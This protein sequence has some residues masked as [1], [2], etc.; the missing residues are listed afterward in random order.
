MMD[1]IAVLI[2]V[3]LWIFGGAAAFDSHRTNYG[4]VLLGWSVINIFV[5][6]ATLMFSTVFWALE[7]VL[8]MVSI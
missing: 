6:G 7:R 2:L 5:V 8:L 4:N 3:A 1:S